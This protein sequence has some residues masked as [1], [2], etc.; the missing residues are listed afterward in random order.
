MSAAT[1]VAVALLVAVF[2]A[3][4]AS[5]G[6]E[7]PTAT[8][9]TPTPP[10][11]TLRGIDFTAAPYAA[12]LTRR[13]GGGDVIAERVRLVDLT[14]DGTEEAVVVVESGGTLGDL[15]VGVY[16][17]AANGPTLTYFRKLAGRVE[18]RQ[19]AL[20]IVEGVP[21]PGDP[22]CC[23]SQVRESTVEWRNGTFEVTS[24]RTVAAPGTSA[25]PR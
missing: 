11:P 14:G 1:W 25:T 10:P 12:D 18:I 21:A 20:V 7:T 15:G 8:P 17:A 22:E 3:C 6:P 13:A 9:G 16:Q 19:A 23:P 2:A 24:E 4:G 5:T